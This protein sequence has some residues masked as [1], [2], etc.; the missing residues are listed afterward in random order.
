[1]CLPG[2]SEI[3]AWPKV[4][5]AIRSYHRPNAV[6]V[7]GTNFGTYDCSV[8][9]AACTLTLLCLHWLCLLG[10]LHATT[11]QKGALQ[12]STLPTK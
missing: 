8:A 11:T 6:P 4:S 7:P 9:Y 1:M 10:L 3:L 2:L 5:G 12:L